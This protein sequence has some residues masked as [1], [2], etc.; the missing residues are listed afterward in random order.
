MV[1]LCI[2]F[3]GVSLLFILLTVVMLCMLNEKFNMAEES[4]ERAHKRAEY[5][6]SQN[7][8]LSKKCNAL[9]ELYRD[10]QTI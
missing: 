2:A 8:E 5:Y 1:K 3:M 4:K 6:Y 7:I 9:R 10:E